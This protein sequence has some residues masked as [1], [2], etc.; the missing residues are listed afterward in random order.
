[1]LK[2]LLPMLMLALLITSPSCGTDSDDDT[3]NTGGSGS[4]SILGSCTD[5][6]GVACTE[7][8]GP[9]P[10]AETECGS[11]GDTWA[12]TACAIADVAGKCVYDMGEGNTSTAYINSTWAAIME[13]FCVDG[14]GYTATWTSL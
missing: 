2:K 5:A 3:D 7:Y 4:S 8:V 11:E 14:T 1:M 13:A 12:T 9:W 10:N 6:D